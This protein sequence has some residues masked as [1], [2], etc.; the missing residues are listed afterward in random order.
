MEIKSI[1]TEEARKLLEKES[2]EI[3]KELKK[4]AINEALRRG[5]PVEI[6]ASDVRRAKSLFIRRKI[7]PKPFIDF[8]LKI[9]AVLG[10]ILFSGGFLYPILRE[11]FYRSDYYVRYSFII[12]VA[13]LSLAL[14]SLL[15]RKYFESIYR[16]KSKRSLE[17][18]EEEK[19]KLKK[20][21]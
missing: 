4:A 8:V 2:K 5:E 21:Q 15:A 11:Y 1:F 14:F 7:P 3:F 18:D 16:I 20:N 6:T 17:L 13:G 9:Y 19:S 10:I 12:A